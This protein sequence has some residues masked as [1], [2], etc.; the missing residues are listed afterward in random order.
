M[1]YSCHRASSV[2]LPLLLASLAPSASPQGV[3]VEL[4]GSYVQRL[5]VGGYSLD[6]YRL[7]TGGS[8]GEVSFDELDGFAVHAVDNANLTIYFAR[9]G[10]GDEAWD[11]SFG[12]GPWSNTNGDAPDFFVF[13]A[14][15]NDSVHAAPVLE[16]G[17]VGQAVT[18]SSWS[19]TGYVLEYGP[20][21]GQE[22]HGL[23]F[24]HTE[25][26]DAAGAPLAPGDRLVGLELRAAGID[27]AAL[28][29]VD[30]DPDLAHG[31]GDGSVR[32]QGALRAWQPIEIELS[33]PWAD[34]TDPSPQNPFLDR[35]LQVRLTA[36]GG[37]VFEVPGF[38]DG[39]GSGG[40]RGTTWSARF[41]PTEGGRWHGRSSFRV[42]SEVAVDLAPGAGSPG[43]LD[44]IDFAFDVAPADTGAPGFHGK[45]PLRYAGGHYRRFA[46]G[47]YFVKAGAN[48]PEN[49][50]AFR[51]FDGVGD[52]GGGGNLHDYPPHVGD[53][54]P[55][56]PFFRSNSHQAT[57]QGLVGALNYL[58]SMGV[59]SVFMMLMNLGGDAQDVHPFLGPKR[60][61]F[62]KTHY[63]VGR[64]HQWNLVFEHAARLGI[65]LH[66]GL[67]ETEPENEQWLDDGALG[68]ER[69]LFYREMVARFGHHPAV[70]WTLCEENDYSVALLRQFADYIRALDPWDHAIAVHN[71]PD[72][73]AD[74]T[75]LAGDARFDATSFQY[76]PDL[77]GS[78]VEQL[79]ALSASAGRP[80][81]I[82]M[83]ENNPWQTGLSDTNHHDLRKRVLYDVL[84][85][86]GQIEWY[87][88]WHDLPLG[89]DVTLEDFRTREGMW[90]AV[91]HARRFMEEHLPFW[92]MQAADGLLGGESSAYGGGEVFAEPGEVYAVYLPNASSTGTLDLAGHAGRYEVRWY[93]P[94]SGTFAG[95]PRTVEVAGSLVLGPA[96][97]ASGE[98]W[99]FL[100]TLEGLPDGDDFTADVD[101]ISVARGGVQTLSL[102]PPLAYAGRPYLVLG[103]L[104]GTSP[105]FPW[106][107]VSVPLVSDRYLRATILFANRGH[108]VATRG[109]L[110]ASARGQARIDI[111]AGWSFPGV[112]GRTM[113]HA[114]VLFSASGVDYASVPVALRIVL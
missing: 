52:A 61:R 62:D 89:G 63:D 22:I 46:D 12:A 75:A 36:P 6:V 97:S 1:L 31:D 90:R 64:M 18:F 85:S 15:G 83:D 58:S 19:G 95:E 47:S 35:R 17:S 92:R 44:G 101:A 54:S 111:P 78:F 80:W 84:F 99:V 81:A 10:V 28:L 11:V 96:P 76:T 88:G 71:H 42:G 59:N 110:D 105:G 69:K 98:D 91:G 68:V 37:E 74:Y 65:A 27:G 43:M 103:S 114:Y 20:N 86:G 3:D 24:R 2:L 56:D 102:Q 94:R 41:T 45:G 34:M 57:S 79:T 77:A 112:V 21:S 70:K 100:A 113:H 4:R 107:S 30:P 109:I 60:T 104:K 72:S 55:G 48:S 5:S 26:R 50:L 33:G 13:E 38:F 82:D 87:L 8:D 29:F 9:S 7:G 108:L 53:W 25:L 40:A 66:F 39:D 49:L 51:G 14:G 23:A 93:D 106:G 16:G 67:A 73:F 32:V